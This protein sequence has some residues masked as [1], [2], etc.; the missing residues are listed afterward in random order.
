MLADHPAASHSGPVD[1]PYL[2]SGGRS[3][4]MSPRRAPHLCFDMCHG[5]GDLAARCLP[6]HLLICLRCRLSSGIQRGQAVIPRHAVQGPIDH[7][8][9]PAAPSLAVLQRFGR[10]T[11]R[12]VDRSVGSRAGNSVRDQ[13]AI[14]LPPPSRERYIL[15]RNRESQSRPGNCD[16]RLGNAIYRE[17]TS[18]LTSMMVIKWLW[19]EKLF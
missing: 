19:Y 10:A 11:T 1:F 16:S 14:A 17:L 2:A 7:C 12:Y 9:L 6:F 13:P 15:G 4:T 3:A 8:A 18:L 5:A